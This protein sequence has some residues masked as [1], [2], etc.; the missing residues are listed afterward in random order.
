MRYRRLIFQVLITMLV[1]VLNGTSI[2][3]EP[4]PDQ[5][6]PKISGLSDTFVC[7]VVKG[8]SYNST[9]RM[10]LTINELEVKDVYFDKTDK[11]R[12]GETIDV[13]TEG[14]FKG[15]KVL[16][17]M[18][19]S[20]EFT[21]ETMYIVYLRWIQGLNGFKPTTGE[22][23]VFE[24]DAGGRVLN[25]DGYYIVDIQN[26]KLVVGRQKESRIKNTKT[27]QVRGLSARVVD[28]NGNE[29]TIEPISQNLRNSDLYSREPITLEQFL[30]KVKGARK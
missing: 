20:P 30:Q 14:G 7:G 13:I 10:P 3:Y 18:L 2:A 27:E 6:L 22:S 4:M 5:T 16:A 9:N 28:I 21:E 17:K 19:N 11:V 26:G 25:I 1:L 8:I 23:S 12:A 15:N 29:T 24:V